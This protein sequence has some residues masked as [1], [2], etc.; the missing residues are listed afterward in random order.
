MMARPHSHTSRFEVPEE[1]RN[2]LYEA[3]FNIFAW[4]RSR[5]DMEACICA[6]PMA[7]RSKLSDLC[8]ELGVEIGEVLSEI[9]DHGLLTGKSWDDLTQ[10]I[11]HP[12][13]ECAPGYVF[14]FILNQIR[15][16]KGIHVFRGL[17]I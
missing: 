7:H 12:G 16:Q 6:I 10:N 4:D 15:Q 9:S 1:K 8:R 5:Q 14:F 11:D 3:V 17:R 13:V 2:V